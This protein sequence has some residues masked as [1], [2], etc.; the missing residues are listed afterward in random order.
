MRCPCTG[1]IS[2]QKLIPPSLESKEGQKMERSAGKGKRGVTESQD[3]L[4]WGLM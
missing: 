2:P 4:V 3:G 1:F